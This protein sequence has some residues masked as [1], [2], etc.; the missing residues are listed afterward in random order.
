[1]FFLF[2]PQKVAAIYLR[3][4]QDSECYRKI[5]LNVLFAENK[6]QELKQAYISKYN[7][8]NNSDN[9]CINCL[10]GLLSWKNAK[11]LIK[12]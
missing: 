2:L 7:S 5:S 12:Y 9:Y 6:R 1:M 8:K 10:D 11:Y 4:A 3:V